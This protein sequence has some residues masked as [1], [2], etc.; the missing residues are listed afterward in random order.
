MSKCVGNVG[1]SQRRGFRHWATIKPRAEERRTC[2]LTQEMGMGCI[3][4]PIHQEEQEEIIGKPSTHRILS[5]RFNMSNAVR[6]RHVECLFNFD[7]S[8]E[9]NIC[10]LCLFIAR[11][12]AWE[13]LWSV[14]D[15]RRRYIISN[16]EAWC[17]TP[18]SSYLYLLTRRFLL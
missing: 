18:L 8:G 13:I 16:T 15:R 17:T 9:G 11:W 2:E 3:L 1:W 5:N 12:S 14:Q 4:S 7:A 6:R 10:N